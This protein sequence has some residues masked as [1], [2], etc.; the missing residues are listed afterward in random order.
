[1]WLF[2]SKNEY[3][4]YMH[5]IRLAKRYAKTLENMA[6]T[7]ELFINNSD[8][9]LSYQCYELECIIEI[10]KNRIEK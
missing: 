3:K 1:M 5:N 9:D 6:K 10:F 8:I 7:H 2:M 4:A